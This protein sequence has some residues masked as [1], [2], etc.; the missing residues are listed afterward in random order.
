MVVV[1]YYQTE[2]GHISRSEA[3]DNWRLACQVKIKQDMKIKVPDEIFSIQ[4]WEATVT[5]NNNVATFIKELI[6]DLP[7][8][9]NVDFQAGG[10]I[11]IDIPEY[12]IKYST[13]KFK[14]GNV[15]KLNEKIN[16]ISSYHCSKLNINT[17]KINKGMLKK[18]FLRAIKL[19]HY[20]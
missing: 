5:S 18:I 13:H 17:H 9:E 1:T 3:K 8:G 20:G 6:L 16:L 15:V 2:T 12:D 4:K 10:Y 14:H 7:K 11:Q 19:S